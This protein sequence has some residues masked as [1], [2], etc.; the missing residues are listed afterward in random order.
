MVHASLEVV[1]RLEASGHRVT[2]ACPHDVRR[3]IERHGIEFRQLPPVRRQPAPERPRRA[4]ES[5]PSHKW[6]EWS[7]RA[8]RRSEGTRALGMESVEALLEEVSPD[9]VLVDFDLEEHVITCATKGYRTVILSQ[10]FEFKKRPGLPPLGSQLVKGGASQRWWAWTRYRLR[11]R[12]RIA[13]TYLRYF[14]T[15]RRG[16]IREYAR[17]VGFP[18]SGLWPHDWSTLFAFGNLPVWSM[19]AGELDFPHDPHGLFTYIGPMVREDRRDD[20]QTLDARAKL[21]QVVEQARSNGRRVLYASFTSMSS[22][23]S[24]KGASK[25]ANQEAAGAPFIER[26]VEAVASR[27]DWV[28][29]LGFGGD[30]G[31]LE[32]LRQRMGG[33]LPAQIEPCLWA[34]QLYA[35]ENAD[36]FIT[37]SGIHSIHE[38]LLK[39]TPM[40]VYSASAFDQDGCAARL[41]FHRAASVGSRGESAIDIASRLSAALINESTLKRADELQARLLRYEGVLDAAVST[42]LAAPVSA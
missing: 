35:L 15:D 28:L 9:L 42:Q 2:Y 38:A 39:G 34:P 27:D 12:V 11:S 18:K 29:V 3:I 40:V 41:S 21:A 36:L 4:G 19:T 23:G 5:R 22:N 25:G 1:R 17:C 31:A 37:H 32:A 14:G 20:E 24:S 30:E 8:Q 13:S 7:T 26:L 16:V 33:T 6:A 10:W